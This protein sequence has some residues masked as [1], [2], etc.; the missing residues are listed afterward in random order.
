MVED[1]PIKWETSS[2]FVYLFYFDP[3]HDVRYDISSGLKYT[4]LVLIDNGIITPFP[5][6]SAFFNFKIPHSYYN[7]G[8]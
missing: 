3:V 4:D 2:I 7:Y 6:I 5:P 1:K 8:T